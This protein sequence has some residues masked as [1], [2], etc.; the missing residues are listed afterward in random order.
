[1][2]STRNRRSK[3]FLLSLRIKN[4]S[5]KEE[6]LKKCFAQFPSIKLYVDNQLIDIPGGI[7][8]K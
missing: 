8:K 6:V 5:I 3:T 2:W 4:C 7:L 1:M